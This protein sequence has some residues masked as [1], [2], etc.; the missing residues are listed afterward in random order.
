MIVGNLP[1]T[2]TTVFTNLTY[3]ALYPISIQYDKTTYSDP[4][5]DAITFTIANDMS[6]AW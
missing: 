5:G 4:N 2:T 1:P 3:I 6:T